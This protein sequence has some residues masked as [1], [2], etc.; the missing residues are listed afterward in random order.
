MTRRV[1]WAPKAR[2]DLFHHLDYIYNESPG[3]AELVRD[4]IL[5]RVISLGQTATGR[6][7]RVF[8]TYEAYVPKTS[9][10]IS[11]EVPDAKTLHVLRIIHAKR[12][13]PEGVWPQDVN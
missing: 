8:G 7:G 12:N 6:T 11:Y 2:K 10:I 13:W 1:I 4:R 9:L 3:N 5:L